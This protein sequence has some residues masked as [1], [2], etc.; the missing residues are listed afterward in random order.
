MRHLVAVAAGTFPVAAAAGVDCA[1]LVL[2]P[3][4]L[5]V[6]KRSSSKFLFRFG[7][8]LR[9]GLDVSSPGTQPGSWF[10]PLLVRPAHSVCRY[11]FGDDLDHTVWSDDPDVNR[12]PQQA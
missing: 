7:K 8:R 1:A 2:Q 3:E 9:Y 5:I 10:S 6:T 12:V 11:R 4:K